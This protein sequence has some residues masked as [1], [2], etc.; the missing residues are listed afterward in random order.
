MYSLTAIGSQRTRMQ[1]ERT[2]PLLLLLLVL[3]YWALFARADQ[4]THHLTRP[5]TTLYSL[6]SDIAPLSLAHN[7]SHRID[8]E[9]LALLQSGIPLAQCTPGSASI[10]G[11]I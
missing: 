11:L 8:G 10:R 3:S 7:A 5:E 6:F 2:I 9:Y 1:V 4:R